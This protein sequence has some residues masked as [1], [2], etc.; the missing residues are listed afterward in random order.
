[1][2]K[3]ADLRKEF[4]KEVAELAM[5]RDNFILEE[6]KKKGKDVEDDFGT[7]VNKC[8]QTKAA[9]VGYTKEVN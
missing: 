5:Q 4:Q 3:K 9:K 8:I 2:K 7:S 1:V 6:Q